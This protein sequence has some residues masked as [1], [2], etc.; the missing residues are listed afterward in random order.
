MFGMIL[1]FSTSQMQNRNLY[2]HQ[3]VYFGMK[4][5]LNLQWDFNA[6]IMVSVDGGSDVNTV[7]IQSGPVHQSMQNCWQHNL[8]TGIRCYKPFPVLGWMVGY[9]FVNR[10]TDTR[11][12]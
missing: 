6:I 12:S 9:T 4:S 7:R 3:P 10:Y 11:Y 8:R 1:Y 5:P 2:L